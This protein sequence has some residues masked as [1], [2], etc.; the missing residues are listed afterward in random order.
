MTQSP[1]PTLPPDV[2]RLCAAIAEAANGL[3]ALSLMEV[4]GTHTH[5]VRRYGIRSLLPANVKLLSGPGCP[6]CVTAEKDVA[7]ALALTKRPGVALCCFGDMLRVPAG[8]ESL[9]AQK[10]RGADVR[11]CVSPMDALP[12]AKREPEKTFVWFG[13]GFETTAPNTAALAEAA[14]AD[15]VKNLFIL[16]AHKT[17]PNALR[18]LLREETGV[19][20]LL[21]PGHVAAVTGAEAFRFLPVELGLPA[22]ISGFEPEEILLAVFALVKMLRGKKPALFNAYPRVVHP[23]GNRAARALLNRV[24]EPCAAVWRGMGEIPDSGL[25]LKREY[26]ALDANARW[27]LSGIDCTENSACRCGDVLRGRIEPTQCV[28]FGRACTPQNPLGA[29]MVSSEGTCAAYYQYER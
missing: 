25:R 26:A 16:S 5:A 18:A 15:G 1:N 8:G 6:V 27:N 14:L 24:F 17:M 22:A 13:V 28:C 19:S 21:C 3:P 23:D 4:C 10:E 12:A 29:C 7:A 9:L 20:A 11:V 2:A